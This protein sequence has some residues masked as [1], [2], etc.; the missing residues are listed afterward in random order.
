MPKGGKPKGHRKQS[1]VMPNNTDNT[2][3]TSDMTP[4]STTATLGFP[5]GVWKTTM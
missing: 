5:K 3:S 4:A 2:K 1:N